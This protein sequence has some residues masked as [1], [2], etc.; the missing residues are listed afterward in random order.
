MTETPGE[1]HYKERSVFMKEVNPQNFWTF[2]SGTQE[3]IWILVGL[4]RRDRQPNQTL[5]NDT[6][7]RPPQRLH[8]VLLEQKKIVIRLFY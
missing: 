7:Y 1:L 5:N 8:I 2:E 6:F 3:G 4:H